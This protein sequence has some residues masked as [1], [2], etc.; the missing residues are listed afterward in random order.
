M[1]LI[2]MGKGASGKD[3]VKDILVKKHG[4]HS[5][6]TYTTRPMRKGEIPDITY[7]YIQENEFL[8]KIKSNF[9]AE[10]KKY[11]INGDIWYYGSAKEDLESTDEDTVVILTPD[12]IRDIR[13]NGIDATVI[14]LYSN[15][16][17]I[18]KRLKFR[19]D[20]NDAVEDR[21]QRDIKLFKDAESLADRII[22]NNENTNINDLIDNVIFHYKTIREKVK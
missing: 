13:K 21:I 5:I 7:H 2:L 19:N 20:S 3:T 15:L 12:G 17:T 14:Y 6:V 8:Q 10:W 1:C 18:R 11:T 16:N 9:F 4:F 22:Y